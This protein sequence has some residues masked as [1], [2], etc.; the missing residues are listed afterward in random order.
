MKR[1]GIY[2]GSFDPVHEGHLAFAKTA[3][4]TAELD[5]IV[6]LPEMMPREKPQITPLA[7]RFLD[8]QAKTAQHKQLEVIN[9]PVERFTITDTLTLLQSQFTGARLALL[10]GSDVA[11]TFQHRWPG[12]GTLLSSTDLIIGLREND[13]VQD[14]EKIMKSLE[15]THGQKIV[16]SIVTTHYAHIASSKIR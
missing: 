13:S 15:R 1:V 8:L 7:T 3:L 4:E 6:F 2:P 16:Y 5:T 14:M 9:L 11:Y 10:V 12:L